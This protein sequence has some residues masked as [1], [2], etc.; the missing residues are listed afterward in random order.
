[1]AT[2]AALNPHE[3]VN[4]Q[5]QHITFLP[6]LCAFVNLRNLTDTTRPRYRTRDFIKHL[7]AQKITVDAKD[8]RRF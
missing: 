3:R 1:M 6:R 7:D 8:L 5:K 4:Q 2:R